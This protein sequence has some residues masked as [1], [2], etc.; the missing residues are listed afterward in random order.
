[1]TTYFLVNAGPFSLQ[2]L[3][4]P[5]YGQWQLNVIYAQMPER[6]RGSVGAEVNSQTASFSRLPDQT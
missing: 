2:Q 1:M 4:L 5:K 6:E 3:F